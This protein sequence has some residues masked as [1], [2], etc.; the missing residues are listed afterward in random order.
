MKKTS[1]IPILFVVVF[2]ASLA[3]CKSGE[4]ASSNPT[5]KPAAEAP[6]AANNANQSQPSSAAS[7]AAT[8][9]P[10]G[11]AEPKSAGKSE[12]LGTYESREVHDKGVVTVISQLRTLWMFSSDGTYSRVSEVKGKPYH[13]DSG[14]FRIEPPDKL[15]LSIQM[16]GL[17][18][19]RKMQNPPLSKTHKFELSADGEE[20]RLTS[21]KGS[22][23]IF[24]RVSSQKGQ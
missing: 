7:A 11:P 21:E 14:T 1:A 17:K 2:L 10:S 8:G 15:V 20:L 16:T 12:L 18:T 13:A 22:I 9:V 24:R 19:Q 23:G 5:N 6:A 4:T 3:G